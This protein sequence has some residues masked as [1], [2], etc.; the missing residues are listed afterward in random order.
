MLQAFLAWVQKHL[1][2]C[3]QPL[4][5][6]PWILD[7]DT[8]HTLSMANL[9]LILDVEVQAGNEI[10]QSS[11]QSLFVGIVVLELMA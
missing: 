8:Y 4:L 5:T 11:G 2:K 3:Y 1:Q 6:I 10:H 7:V 9:R